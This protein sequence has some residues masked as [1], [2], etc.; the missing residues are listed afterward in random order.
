MVDSYGFTNE[1]STYCV[2]CIDWIDMYT[3]LKMRKLLWHGPSGIAIDMCKYCVYMKIFDVPGL[4][5]ELVCTLSRYNVFSSKFT[6]QNCLEYNDEL[7]TTKSSRVVYV[8]DK[9][10]L[11]DGCE[12]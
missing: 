3:S 12:L 7:V 4:G 9:H 10:R 11:L 5:P 8:C 6:T 2:L 1:N